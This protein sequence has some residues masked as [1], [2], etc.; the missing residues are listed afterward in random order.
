MSVLTQKVSINGG[1]LES[2]T[3]SLEKGV[4][5]ELLATLSSF[6]EEPK[7]DDRA[8]GTTVAASSS[9]NLTTTTGPSV[10]N[11]AS[12]ASSSG[13][14]G[15]GDN[16][17]DAGTASPNQKWIWVL[18]PLTRKLRVPL[19]LLV[20]TQATAVTGTVPSLCIGFL[21]G[22]CRHPWCRQAHVL[23]QAISQLR[24][25]AL[26]APTCCKFHEDPHDISTLTK[27]YTHIRIVNGPS[28]AVTTPSAAH[29]S[30]TTGGTAG[31]LNRGASQGGIRESGT[32][33]NRDGELNENS[34]ERENKSRE[35]YG[36][37][38]K[39]DDDAL[40]IN[41]INKIDEAQWKAVLESADLIPTER[42]AS[43]V[44]LLRYLVHCAPA[45]STSVVAPL[46]N[47]EKN[48]EEKRIISERITD[49]GKN[50]GEVHADPNESLKPLP[51]LFC[52]SS[53]TKETE[54]KE[55]KSG[56]KSMTKKK[57]QLL[58]TSEIKRLLHKLQKEGY[59]QILE[60]PSKSICRL[61]LSHRCRYLEDCNNIHICRAYESWIPPQPTILST[62]LHLNENI[63]TVVLNDTRYDVTPLSLGDVKDEDFQAIVEEEREQFM[64]KQRNGCEG[65]VPCTTFSVAECPLGGVEVNS[66]NSSSMGDT[67]TKNVGKGTSDTPG[68]NGGESDHKWSSGWAVIGNT[69]ESAVTG[70]S[71]TG[72]GDDDK[73]NTLD[74]RS[75]GTASVS[76][77]SHSLP[78]AAASTSLT[79]APYLPSPSLGSSGL[80][81]STPLLHTGTG[82]TTAYSN[83]WPP[84]LGPSFR[85]H[86]LL[87]KHYSRAVELLGTGATVTGSTAA[88]TPLLHG[89]PWGTS[90][91]STLRRGRSTS[92]F[93]GPIAGPALSPVAGVRA[94]RHSNSSRH[95][96][97]QPPP[98]PPP[99]P[100][101]P[102][103]AASTPT[104][105]L[106]SLHPLRFSLPPG[107]HPLHSSMWGTPGSG[108]LPLPP[109]PS[110]PPPPPPPHYSSLGNSVSW[111]TVAPQPYASKSGNGN[112]G[113][114]PQAPS[115]T[116]STPKGSGLLFPTAT[117][118]SLSTSPITVTPTRAL[119]ST[120]PPSFLPHSFLNT[121]PPSRTD[122]GNH[123]A[124]YPTGGAGGRS[125]D[126]TCGFSSAEFPILSGISPK[127]DTS[128]TR[129]PGSGRISE[130]EGGERDGEKRIRT[131]VPETSN[132]TFISPLIGSA[133]H[134]TDRHNHSPFFCT[135]PS[136]ISTEA[137]ASSS[138]ATLAVEGNGRA[139][140]ASLV[141][142]GPY[143]GGAE[144]GSAAFQNCGSTNDRLRHTSG[145]SSG[146]GDHDTG[147]STTS[148]S[149]ASPGSAIVGGVGISAA[150]S[151]A[152]SNASGA[153]IGH[154]S[155]GVLHF[156]TALSSH[157]ATDVVT[158]T[159]STLPGAGKGTS[160]SSSGP[161]P[162]VPTYLLHGSDL[163]GTSSASIQ[164]NRGCM[165]DDNSCGNMSNSIRGRSSSR[166]SNPSSTSS[167][168]GTGVR[169][170]CT[171][172]SYTTDAAS[173]DRTSV[174]ASPSYLPVDSTFSSLPTSVE[175]LAQKPPV[176]SVCGG[177]SSG[178]PFVDPGI[179]SKLIFSGSGEDIICQSS[180]SGVSEEEGRVED[181]LL[182][183]PQSAAS[184]SH[185][186][187]TSDN[188][189]LP[190]NSS[191]QMDFSHRF[192]PESIW[193]D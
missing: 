165:N 119:N 167:T 71:N 77:H 184:S 129:V 97:T 60:I 187:R 75:G 1:E 3:G 8:R 168:H 21:E 61:H 117:P 2:A 18:D 134:Y 74:A 115:T 67:G 90:A 64:A 94:G 109:P 175:T 23:P 173:R 183:F 102:L 47:E 136:S 9:S 66:S 181:S 80:T 49:T 86:D 188:E 34:E 178:T 107:S 53:M 89:G 73:G 160:L 82:A 148:T 161:S 29:T 22:R 24:L 164:K 48:R 10:S 54:A 139:A 20:P 142:G 112:G 138:G 13:S 12:N 150:G 79:S 122:A 163:V 6:Q 100:C 35:K 106:H 98:P 41:D 36:E 135:M 121:S 68:D 92:P 95:H 32:S 111:K 159:G 171:L 125:T 28:V 116:S 46:S 154:G 27:K 153:P 93:P 162:F 81:G 158:I 127:R 176:S 11:G 51:F 131:T 59:L 85:V 4:K 186:I 96:Y 189:S 69:D 146:S 40:D 152:S 185:P 123:P 78:S 132:D 44:G 137:T 147:A 63:P 191:F 55:E 38:D 39:E 193:T 72:R 113:G 45:T 174:A 149:S 58:S 157:L 88:S 128:R 166:R 33:S 108:T 177:F 87:S 103:A 31:S 70:A 84:S 15:N 37:E 155:G 25:E 133:L 14:A 118:S 170:G 83:P 151:H 141:G 7:G 50:E 124:H 99:P 144:E 56:E 169:Q 76:Q 156:S 43:T 126:P 179:L 62:L 101:I 182:F 143:D 19:H 5:H 180:H 120:P 145:S 30:F 16:P 57:H 140:A 172:P 26:H 190:H 42:L 192:E 104:A 17:R 105:S 52:S 110:A 114:L 65:T 130:E 91:G